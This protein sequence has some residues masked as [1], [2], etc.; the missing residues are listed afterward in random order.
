[1]T[2]VVRATA[3]ALSAAGPF[4]A[5]SGEPRAWLRA[6]SEAAARE[7]IAPGPTTRLSIAAG[8]VAGAHRAV[9][10]VDGS[11]PLAS[12][13]PEVLALTGEG[14]VAAEA[15]A[16]GWRV[17]QPWAGADVAGLLAETPLP[18]L[19]FLGEH[20]PVDDPDLS[21]AHAVREWERGELATIAASGPA[22]GTAVRL[23]SRLRDRGVDIGLLELAVL[24]RPEHAPLAGG[25]AIFVAGRGAGQAWRQGDWPTA[26][27]DTVPLTGTDADLIGAVLSLVPVG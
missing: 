25:D 19:L 14:V 13:A 5:V 12:R 23:A 18:A 2:D 1:M 16:L 21:A 10:I 6:V 22:V 3:A 24:T 7:I 20:E 17:I 27:V 15:L 11:L 26:R 4:V 8:V 9:A